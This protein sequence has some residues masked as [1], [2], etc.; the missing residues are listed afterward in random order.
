M[1]PTL[2]R[3]RAKNLILTHGMCLCVCLLLFHAFSGICNLSHMVQRK[4]FSAFLSSATAAVRKVC[5]ADPTGCA[6]SSQGIRGSFSVT[7]TL[8]FIC[9][10]N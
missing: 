7:N 1:Q 4:T 5:S 10:L 6:T 9:F 8:K 2:E 3:K